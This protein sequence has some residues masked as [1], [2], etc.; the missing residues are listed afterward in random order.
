MDITSE[1]AQDHL[2][3]A[4]IIDVR[5]P[6]E[7]KEGHIKRAMNIDINDPDFEGKVDKLDKSKQYLVY[8][9]TGHRSTYAVEIMKSLGFDKIFHLYIGILEWIDSGYPIEKTI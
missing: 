3:Q 5:T 1:E 6:G 8:C 4:E 7:F 9:R 2:S